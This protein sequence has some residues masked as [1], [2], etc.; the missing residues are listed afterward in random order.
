MISLN[1]E[2]KIQHKRTY[3]QKRNSLTDIEIRLVVV[4]GEE[5]REMDGLGIWGW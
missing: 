5:G 1:V 4:K 3:L 2:S